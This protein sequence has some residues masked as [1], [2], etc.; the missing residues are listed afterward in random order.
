MTFNWSN[1]ETDKDLLGVSSGEYYLTIS[2]SFGC[3]AVTHFSVPTF[4][5]DVSTFNSV[6]CGDEEFQ[7]YFVID[8][9]EHVNPSYNYGLFQSNF[10]MDD[11]NYVDP[12]IYNLT[13]SYNNCHFQSEIVIEGES[14]LGIELVS[15]RNPKS[16]VS[17]D[18]M[19]EVKSSS[20][21]YIS[22][23]FEGRVG[24][25]ITELGAGVFKA[26]VHLGYCE[27][28][29]SY[30]LEADKSGLFD[31][32]YI[33]QA[34][35]LSSGVVQQLGAI[36]LGN[37]HPD[38]K[39]K[40]LNYSST[41]PFI[42]ELS[43]A[44]YMVEATLNKCKQNET[45][46]I[47]C[48]KDVNP[49]EVS[50]IVKQCTNAFSKDGS[51][52]ITGSN[53]YTYSWSSSNGF[54][55]NEKSVFDLKAGY[56]NLFVSDGC[57][58]K[59]YKFLIYNVEE[60][61]R[62]QI[63]IFDEEVCLDE[64]IENH[65][66]ILSPKVGNCISCQYK[67]STGSTQSFI[68]IKRAGEY[69]VTVTDINFCTSDYQYNINKYK[70]LDINVIINPYYTW[71]DCYF[72]IGL[73]SVQAMDDKNYYIRWDKVGNFE[74]MGN[75]DFRYYE[76]LPAK[77]FIEIK[78]CGINKVIE[79]KFACTK[80]NGDPCD[81]NI[82]ITKE[83]E[84][85]DECDKPILEGDCAN[86]ICKSLSSNDVELSFPDGT[87]HILS[88]S[89]D[90]FV[91]EAQFPDKFMIYAVDESGCSKSFLV[92]Y[93]V[94][95]EPSEWNSDGNFDSGDDVVCPKLKNL[96]IEKGED[97]VISFDLN[98]MEED[99]LIRFEIFSNSNNQI[100]QAGNLVAFD[101]HN[102]FEI[103]GVELNDVTIRLSF[104]DFQECNSMEKNLTE[105]VDC[106]QP[107]LAESAIF[108]NTARV[109]ILCSE[110]MGSATYFLYKIDNNKLIKVSERTVNLVLGNNLEIFDISHFPENTKFKVDLIFNSSFT[111]CGAYSVYFS[112]I[113][114]C[115]YFVGSPSFANDLFKVKIFSSNTKTI[116]LTLFA[117]QIAL[118]AK[119]LTINPGT[120]LIEFEYS[121]QLT[122]VYHFQFNVVGSNCPVAISDGVNAYIQYPDPPTEGCKNIIDLLYLHDDLIAF[123]AYSLPSG[124]FRIIANK[125]DQISFD[126]LS[127]F[128]EFELSLLPNSIRFDKNDNI[129]TFSNNLDTVVVSNFTQDGSLIWNKSIPEYS[130]ASV[131]SSAS[132]LGYLVLIRSINSGSYKKI[133]IN[134]QGNIVSEIPWN[135]LFATNDNTQKQVFL[136]NEIDY[137][138]VANSETNTMVHSLIDGI[139]TISTFNNSLK[140]SDVIKKN[141]II[142]IVGAVKDSFNLN[143][144]LQY[145][146]HYSS[147]VVI[148]QNTRQNN[149]FTSG[150]IKDFGK[151]VECDKA[152]DI[153]DE[154]IIVVK[155]PLAGFEDSSLLL[156]CDDI[157][158][159]NNSSCVCNSLELFINY[160]AAECKLTWDPT[161]TNF[162]FVLQRYVL[163]QWI[164]IP[165]SSFSYEL[166]SFDNGT[167]RLKAHNDSCGTFYGNPLSAIGCTSP[168]ACNPVLNKI[169]CHLTWQN[170]CPGYVYALQIKSVGGNWITVNYANSP[171]SFVG[172]EGVYRL[173]LSKQGCDSK[174]SN[175][176]D[177]TCNS[178]AN[179]DCYSP[180]INYDS[181]NCIL[182][183]DVIGCLGYS[184]QLERKMNSSWLS[185]NTNGNNF[186]SLHEQDPSYYRL[187]L[188]KSE[189]D[190][191]YSGEEFYYC[192]WPACVCNSLSLDFDSIQCTLS[193]NELPCNGFEKMLQLKEGQYWTNIINAESP[194]NVDQN[195]YGEYRLLLEKENCDDLTS[196]VVNVECISINCDL[197]ATIS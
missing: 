184:V 80:E 26:T 56:Y 191:I 150:F 13:I 118:G 187:K 152:V 179:C 156:I 84:C 22:W 103:G 147:P 106:P 164:D 1:G 65:T 167:Y 38:T 89:G 130:I 149:S 121:V 117:G 185:V 142:K 99:L 153:N 108:E 41:S 8:K 83:K 148:S 158:S 139:S 27:V 178:Y 111:S 133:E 18:G 11:R 44:M 193:W 46:F 28:F 188:Y 186:L 166:P 78:S 120:N 109:S 40:W 113:K 154:V 128:S 112:K 14:D 86:I 42:S 157:I 168:C 194:Y 91:Y 15:L 110:Q 159:A 172:K 45:Y 76:P 160:S 5:F 47:S 183:W 90:E 177:A 190:T 122:S 135:F 72:N 34:E 134:Q 6:L 48:C 51:I 36:Q 127:K 96:E 155:T 70:N 93:S 146:R 105:D 25:K 182:S 74:L 145:N 58:M 144:L 12:G 124:N 79:K 29:N 35:C 181:D 137:S 176:I 32:T 73:M 114:T 77:S 116:K 95:C 192:T 136:F 24:S 140:I 19:I 138:V 132:L 163:S 169:G 69:T 67:W 162:N 49:I 3:T 9:P 61:S 39:F 174:Y 123:N 151:E 37:Y 60:C 100:L 119:Q 175:E 165:T 16:C 131:P 101:G 81:V 68:E 97:V 98:L 54:S 141:D 33:K 82:S 92:D 4:S 20:Q 10:K 23:D 87:V 71:A 43:P 64:S 171:F 125:I 55:S 129:L 107:L 88:N 50:S 85:W 180:A 197:L 31:L 196:E 2:N 52:E 59:D 30:V 104:P 53:N 173:K 17:E 66:Q 75:I 195:N 170:T 189:C 161:C 7:G 115:P 57:S 21:A 143:G 94:I 102:E 62:T 126:S 63:T